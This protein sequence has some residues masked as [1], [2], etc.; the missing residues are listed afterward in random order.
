[1]FCTWSVTL[2]KI[3]SINPP[4]PLEIT[5]IEPPLPIGI[6]NDLPWGGGGGYGY[7]L[8]PHNEIFTSQHCIAALN[9]KQGHFGTTILT[10]H[11]FVV[12]YY[13]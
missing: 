12:F 6:S 1:M 2:W 4:Y 7:F 3:L 9:V 13:N 5:T 11:N 8:E 10:L